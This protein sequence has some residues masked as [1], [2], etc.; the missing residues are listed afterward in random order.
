MNDTAPPDPGLSDDNE[1]RVAETI[2]FLI[3]G[4][5]IPILAAGGILGKW[6][7]MVLAPLR[8]DIN[9]VSELASNNFTSQ[10]IN[11]EKYWSNTMLSIEIFSIKIQ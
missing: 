5:L 4:I 1:R 11:S 8:V 9:K 10:E 7:Y 6:H 2:A 3:E